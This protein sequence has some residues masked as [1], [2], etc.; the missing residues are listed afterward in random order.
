MNDNNVKEEN[1]VVNEKE[2]EPTE[3]WKDWKLHIAMFVCAVVAQKIGIINIPIGPVSLMLMPLIYAM[4]FGLALYLIK[5]I[6]FISTKQSEESSPLL[7]LA[8]MFLCVKMGVT[9]IPGLASIMSASAILVIQNIGNL[10]TI[11]LALPVAILLGC[12]REAVGLSFS[13]SREPGIAII[14]DKYGAKSKEFQ[15]VMACY[16]VGTIF[17]PV[18]FGMIPGLFVDF[19]W[20]SPEA[21]AMAVGCGSTAMMTSG[22]TVLIAKFPELESQLTGFAMISNVISG[23]LAFYLS[24]F[25]ALP[26]TEKCYTLLT[27]RKAVKAEKGEK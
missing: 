22:L 6:K 7:M 13:L 26:I 10:G 9:M 1:I 20:F 12:K 4:V 8:V 18:F 16:I 11:F 3:L 5:P 27:R 14:T 17:G 23:L 25:L 19:G 2:M 15:G 24:L 21:T